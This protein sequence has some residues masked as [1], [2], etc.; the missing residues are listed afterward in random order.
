M[1]APAL[2]SVY[3]PDIDG[4]RAI[5]VLAVIAFHINKNLLPGGFVGVDVFFV[6]SG[7]LISLHILKDIEL[8]RFSIFDFYRRRVKRI[9]PP[10]LV[11]VLATMVVA[12]LVMIPEDAELA[13]ESAL[14][15][16]FSLANV[17]FWLHHDT[18]Y[19][20]AASSESPLLHL[21]SLGVEEQFYILWPLL[22]MFL[23]RRPRTKVFFVLATLAALASFVGGQLWFQRDPSFVYYMLPT[24]AG[25]LLVGAMVALAVLRRVE[26]RLPAHVI[27]PMAATGLLLVGGSLFMITEDQV[28]PGLLA[29]PPTLGAALLILAG[30]CAKNR[31]SNWLAFKPLVGVG[32]VSYSAYLWHWPLIAFFRYGHHEVGIVAGIVIVALTFLLAWL[33]YLFIEQPARASRA[34]ITKVMLAQYFVP[35]GAIA[36]LALAAMVID[37]YGFRWQSQPYTGRLKAVRDQTRPA[38]Q[39]DYV[40]QRQRA[41]VVDT[42]NERCV[43]GP[44]SAGSPRVILWGDS[45]AAH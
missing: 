22:L 37:G 33:S 27:G 29:I 23:Y 3:R 4:L 32:L 26:D 8:E 36:V 17:Y 43:L 20:A 39:F 40:C 30:H 10:M 45:N 15:S 9:A 44:Q 16:V 41:S 2:N 25:E 18:S 34:S 11:V 13:A 7:F 31:V 42:Q 1:A 21:W 38:Y 24:R 12:Q 6:I 28:F 14:W 19:F 5:A 35:A